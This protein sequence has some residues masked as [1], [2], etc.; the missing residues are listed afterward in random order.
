MSKLADQARQQF[1]KELAEEEEQRLKGGAA[2]SPESAPKLS[3]GRVA[4]KQQTQGPARMLRESLAFM[5]VRRQMQVAV[6]QVHVPEHYLRHPGEY[7]TPKF[8]ELMDS[9]RQSN[10]NVDPIDVR[11]KKQ[12]NG[13]PGYEVI[14]G[15]RRFEAVKRLGLKVVFVNERD[16]DDAM[17]DF[18][19]DIEN[20]KRAEKRPFSLAMELS[21]MWR[22]G[23]Y[24]SQS[25]LADRLGRNKGVVSTYLAL[26]DKAPN[27]LWSRVKDPV[28][29]KDAEARLLV[30]AYDKPQ[31]AEWV[32][33][34]KKTD[35]AP[36]ATVVR[37]AKEMTARPKPPK[38]DIEK[39]REVERGDAYHVVLPKSL[40]AEV[41][42]KVLAF[43]KEIA[44]KL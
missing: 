18:L 41:R 31:F 32:K 28:E 19:H 10:G 39:I 12:S 22:S 13:A 4:G 23:R 33:T 26:F 43:A 20:A 1:E 3:A 15:T 6:D 29:L 44:S 5:P 37:K 8:K 2:P 17:A 21:S 11:F 27:D 40:P 34:L 38:T 30:K 7:E 16:V 14:A 25:E 42:A 36:L 9:I 35:P 24:A